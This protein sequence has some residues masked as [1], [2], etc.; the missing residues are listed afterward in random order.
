MGGAWGICLNFL[1]FIWKWVIN[2]NLTLSVRTVKRFISWSIC[3]IK[4]WLWFYSISWSWGCSWCLWI[5]IINNLRC[6]CFKK[7]PNFTQSIISFFEYSWFFLKL[8]FRINLISL[9]SKSLT[10]RLRYFW[11]KLIIKVRILCVILRNVLWATLTSDWWFN[12]FFTNGCELRR[13]G[14]DLSF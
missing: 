5:D 7:C 1:L 11:V 4:F 14:I 2:L 8:S 10:G 13:S 12:L 3:I 6:H 9:I